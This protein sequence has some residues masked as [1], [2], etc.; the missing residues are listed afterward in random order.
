MTLDL[1]KLKPAY[2]L[3]SFL[4]WILIYRNLLYSGFEEFIENLVYFQQF[5]SLISRMDE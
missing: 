3:P 1:G 2:V 5:L 4:E